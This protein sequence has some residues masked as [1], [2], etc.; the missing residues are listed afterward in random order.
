MPKKLPEKWING[1]KKTLDVLVDLGLKSPRPSLKVYKNDKAN[2]KNLFCRWLPV[3]DE[4]IRDFKGK[5]RL[6]Y[7]KLTGFDDPYEAGKFAIGWLKDLLK[8]I[9]KEKEVQKY[10]SKTSLEHYWHQYWEKQVRIFNTQRNA[11]RRIRDEKLK[12]QG[13]VYG[14]VHQNW[15]KKS[16]EEINFVDMSNYFLLLDERGKEKDKDMA[17]TKKQQKTLINKLLSE[18]RGSDFPSLPDLVFPKI[19]TRKKD[20]V[21]WFSKTEWDKLIDYVVHRSGDFANRDL[22]RD[23]Y[24]KIDWTHRNRFNN[25]RN[26]IDLYD[27]LLTQWFFYLRPEDMPRMRMEWFSIEE[28]YKSESTGKVSPRAVLYLGTTKGDREKDD[29]YAYR[30]EHLEHIRRLIKRRGKKGWCWFDF[31]NRPNNAPSESQVLNT[32]N[33]M[34]KK[35]V[36]ELGIEKRKVN[37]MMIRH[38]AFALTANELPMLRDRTKLQTFAENGFTDIKMFDETYLRKTEASKVADLAS[39]AFD[40]KKE[41]KYVLRDVTS[42][43]DRFNQM[44]KDSRPEQ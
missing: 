26:W 10:N 19:T 7:Y 6:P 9:D 39:T 3:L 40:E 13:E 24:L 8:Q 22:T 33:E 30:P 28:D 5:K 21:D 16:V 14:L 15:T 43:L 23:E 12:W 41:P 20:A 17:G 27:A 2:T 31:Y 36:K 34:L 35:A 37:W 44:I 29:S 18:A 4:E 1:E 42:P 38:T 11:P 32:L 25:K